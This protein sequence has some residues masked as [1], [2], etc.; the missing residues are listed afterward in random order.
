MRPW[1]PFFV[2]TE[3]MNMQKTSNA[4][5]QHSP[6]DSWHIDRLDGML[7]CAIKDARQTHDLVLQQEACA[8]LW[9]CC[10]DI[11][12]ELGLPTPA[13]SAEPASFLAYSQKYSALSL[14]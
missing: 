3:N 2:E 1:R 5:C 6:L 9:V 10:P 12:D 14:A 4:A 13:P 7:T 8:W 11:A